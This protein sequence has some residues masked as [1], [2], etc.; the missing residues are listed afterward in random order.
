MNETPKLI[1]NNSDRFQISDNT[2]FALGDIFLVQPIQ[3]TLEAGHI[4]LTHI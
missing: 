4:S 3:E 1:G 2:L